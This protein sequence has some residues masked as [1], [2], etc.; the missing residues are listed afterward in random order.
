MRSSD[1]IN[2]EGGIEAA[3][4]LPQSVFYFDKPGCK[5]S[6]VRIPIPYAADRE[7]VRVL[8]NWVEENIVEVYLPQLTKISIGPRNGMVRFNKRGAE[9]LKAAWAEVE[10]S[11]LLNRVISW[12]GSFVSRL[13]RGS[14]TELNIHTCGFSFDINAEQNP[15]RMK[16][17]PIGR[18]GSVL[19]LVPIFEKH[20]FKWGGKDTQRLDPMHFEYEVVENTKP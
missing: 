20:G 1:G 12:E 11:G 2:I 14:D 17:A 8:N 19:E 13:N 3:A 5:L 9:A 16:P 10:Q 6:F 15:F 7:Q 4:S 18:Y